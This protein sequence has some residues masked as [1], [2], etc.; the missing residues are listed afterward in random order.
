MKRKQK[1]PFV[2]S[3]PTDLYIYSERPSEGAG[4]L[5]Q[6]LRRQGIRARRLRERRVPDVRVINWGDSKAP[7]NFLNSGSAV[8]QAISKVRTGEALSE[9]KVHTVA[10]TKDRKAANTWL[11][12]GS[13]V[14]CRRDAGTGGKGIVIA[15]REDELV[16]CDFYSRYFPKTHEFRVHVF[17]NTAIDVTEKRARIGGQVARTIRSY[18][19]G[20]VFSHNLSVQPQ[21]LEKLKS[22][23][24]SA[25]K[26]LGLDFGAVDVLAILDTENPR[27]LKKHYV[28]EV[29]TAPGLDS[30]TTIECY[31][32][33]IK[34]YLSGT[35]S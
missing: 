1:R 2:K 20:W 35:S 6:E 28:C 11:Q 9:S 5:V 18:D 32:N 33:A 23:C 34:E 10:I 15:S 22:T 27:R 19:N 3:S 24:V 14:L 13:R 25:V 7:D 16:E 21:D 30:P 12:N 8:T 29:N 17:G 26:A 4:I 31:V